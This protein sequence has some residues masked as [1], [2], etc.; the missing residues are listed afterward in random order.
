MDPQMCPKNSQMCFILSH[1]LVKYVLG[2]GP[3]G[4][5]R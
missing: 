1:L 4:Q 2:A 5:W 3:A